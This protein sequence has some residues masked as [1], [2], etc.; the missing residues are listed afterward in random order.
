MQSSPDSHYSLRK[1][2]RCDVLRQ[3]NPAAHGRVTTGEGL[4]C[5]LF[6][7]MFSQVMVM[8][9]VS[10][11]MMMIMTMIVFMPVRAVVGLE[12]RRHLDAGKSMLREERVNLGSLLQPDPV[13]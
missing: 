1:R 12:R 3:K 9:S 10:M 13:V 11:P 6:I 4:S 5:Y 8:M 2:P 7:M